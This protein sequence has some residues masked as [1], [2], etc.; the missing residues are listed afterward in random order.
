[1][2]SA[3]VIDAER[4]VVMLAPTSK[5]ALLAESVFQR[6]GIPCTLCPDMTEVGRELEVGAAVVVV[7]EEA[8]SQ[9]QDDVLTGWLR[10]QPAWS[11]L[12]VLILAR[13]GA[14]STVVARAMD[15]LGNVTVLERPM[16]VAALVS[17]VRSAVRARQR[18][19]Q[20]REHLAAREAAEAA[21]RE[22]DR[23]KDEFLAILAH[24]LRNPL[25]PI[26]NALTVLQMTGDDPELGQ[27]CDMM[28]RQ[29]NHLV[30]LVDDLMEV[31]RITRGK[32]E[33]RMER[34]DL[35]AVVRT[36]VEASRPLIEAAGHHLAIAIPP[37]R[38][39]VHGD[40]VRLA[41]VFANLLNNAAKYTDPGGKIWLGMQQDGNAVVITI[42]DT[43]IGI[44]TAML[45]RVFELFTQVDHGANRAHGGLGIGL[46][47]AKSLVEMHGGTVTASSEGVGKGSEFLVRLPL[48]E[49]TRIATTPDDGVWSPSSATHVSR[50]I[51]VVDDNRDAADTLGA[52]L[53]V[54]GSDVQV[55]Y[56]GKAAILALDTYHPTVVITDIGMP[57]MDG[58]EVARLIRQRPDFKDVPL[59][60][61]T[62]WGQED[63]VRRSLASGFDSHLTKPAH[64]HALEAIFLSLES[65]RAARSSSSS[66]SKPHGGAPGLQQEIPN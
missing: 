51:L 36:A 65:S 49:E 41:Q 56:S 15:L 1:M 35:G 17:A 54:M 52:V 61:L 27:L 55:V 46:T 42:R 18:Q 12:P 9:E 30:R 59:I 3:T 22:D 21:L 4:R 28:G 11:D 50:R 66:A 43:G 31:S 5:D 25:A 23:R 10:A 19:Y 16:R 37:R 7:P 40:P 45:P 33:L 8:V 29:V 57:G 14:D 34:A 39:A 6:A 20:V 44:P 24:E 58:F 38:L 32:I 26:R 64:A 13:P 62:G 2:T 63:D 60:A 48:A 47:L 53:R